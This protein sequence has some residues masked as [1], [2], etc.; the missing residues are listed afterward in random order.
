M[1]SPG[2]Y[3]VTVTDDNN[4][5]QNDTVYIDLLDV[6]LSLSKTTFCEGEVILISSTVTSEI[7]TLSYLWSN[8]DT[9]PNSHVVPGVDSEFIVYVNNT[10][11]TC[12]DTINSQHYNFLPSFF[13]FD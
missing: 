9:T 13:E 2:N 5:S 8:N 6:D 7:D 1:N 12:S 3:F 10:L 4:C 11:T